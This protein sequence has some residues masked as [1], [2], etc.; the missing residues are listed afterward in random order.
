MQILAITVPILLAIVSGYIA[1]RV[2][3]VSKNI[4]QA[5][6]IFS[7]KIAIPALLIGAIAQQDLTNLLNLP[8]IIVFGGAALIVYA[9]VLIYF[10][11]IRKDGLGKSAMISLDSVASNTGIIGFPVL[12]AI[13]GQKALVLASLANIVAV[14][15]VLLSITIL[16]VTKAEQKSNWIGVIRQVKAAMLNPIVLATILGVLLAAAPLEFPTIAVDYFSVF[17]A[18]VA[19]CA[20]FAVGMSINPHAVLKSSVG[21]LSLSF[22]K[23]VVMPAIAMCIS[24][25]ISADPLVTVCAVLCAA[26]PTGKTQFVL[27][28]KYHHAEDLTGQTIAFTTAIGV[29]TLAGWLILLSHLFRGSL[30]V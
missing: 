7:F 16:E 18:A 21:V 4:E 15:F 29:L 5:L 12:H 2:G 6:I 23:L 1:S 28:S 17:G 3:Y 11:F 8:F 14:I 27:A 19:P 25:M 26:L 20:L 22:L 13:F 30:T 9:L 10:H 24:Y